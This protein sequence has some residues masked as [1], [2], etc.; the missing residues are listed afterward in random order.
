MTRR[1]SPQEK[2]N[3]GPRRAPDLQVRE[4]PVDRHAGREVP[5]RVK[6]RPGVP[7]GGHAGCRAP[8]RQAVP[9]QVVE[10][11]V[12][13]TVSRDPR[14]LLRLA[15]PSRMQ[16]DVTE[17]GYHGPSAGRAPVIILALA[18]DGPGG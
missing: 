3:T 17:A 16:A 4:E 7:A 15:A 11:E 2:R 1:S 12:E 10:P 14:P 5:R 9:R 13:Q 6:A 8:A 18:P